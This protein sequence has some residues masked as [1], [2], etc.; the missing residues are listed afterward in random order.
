MLHKRNPKQ[1]QG[2]KQ[3]E[4]KKDL[5][6]CCLQETHFRYRDKH[7]LKVKGLGGKKKDTHSNETKRNTPYFYQTK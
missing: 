3:K 6:I 4:K 1:K 7:K 5:S 2:K